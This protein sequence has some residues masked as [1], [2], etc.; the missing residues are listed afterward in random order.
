LRGD[1]AHPLHRRWKKEKIGKHRRRQIQGVSNPP[2][3]GASE[4]KKRAIRSMSETKSSADP[5]TRKKLD[6]ETRETRY[7][8]PSPQRETEI[9]SS[10]APCRRGNEQKQRAGGKSKMRRRDGSDGARKRC[11]EGGSQDNLFPH[12]RVSGEATNLE[13]KEIPQMRKV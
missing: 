4:E 13:K 9:Q 3:G 5:V 12:R 11:K 10:P 2:I 6:E 1:R 7:T 8:S